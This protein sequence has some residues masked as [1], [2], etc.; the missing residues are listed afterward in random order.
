MK[1]GLENIDEIFKQAFDGFEANVDPS[2]WTNVENSISSGSGVSSTPQVDPSTVAGF[3][4][5]SLAIKMIAGAAILGT[6]ATSAYFIPNLFEEETTI[7]ENVVADEHVIEAA[8]E[9]V[10]TI[11]EENNVVIDNDVV[12]EKEIVSDHN[13]AVEPNKLERQGNTNTTNGNEN[14]AQQDEQG[15]AAAVTP[16]D[17]IKNSVVVKPAPKLIKPIKVEELTKLAVNINVDA[18]KGKAPFTVQFDALGNSEQYFWDFNND[19]SDESS[20]ESPVYVFSEEGTYTVKLTGIDTEGNSKVAYTRIIVEKDYSSSIQTPL[21]NVISPNGDS[22][23]DI[24]KVRGKNISKIQ[25]QIV[26]SKGKPVY[27][28]NSLDDVWDGRDQSGNLLIQGQYYMTVIAIGKD[29]VRHI[30]K[31]VIN[32]FN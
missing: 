30:K 2:V 1:D 32:L 12:D 24:L 19:G 22:E 16:E 10:L 28:M 14:S 15:F 21:Q 17:P 3:A 8:E 20:E 13:L 23:N 25:V 26:D 9:P 4:G 6:V 18:S 7:A 27:F 11:I 31:T 5:K 29:G